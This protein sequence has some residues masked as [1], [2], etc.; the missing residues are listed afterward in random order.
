MFHYLYKD[1]KENDH[2]GS[3]DKESF[4]REVVN[5]E[6]QGEADCSSQATVGDDELVSEG[7]SVPPKLVHHSSEQEDT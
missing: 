6:D 2:D 1:S 4:L 5:Q 7:H 3:R